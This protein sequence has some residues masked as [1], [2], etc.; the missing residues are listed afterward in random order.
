MRRFRIIRRN[1]TRITF[2]DLSEMGQKVISGFISSDYN[3]FRI[4]L[5]KVFPWSKEWG[6]VKA[7]QQMIISDKRG[8]LF[9]SKVGHPFRSKVG[10]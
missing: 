7:N 2:F 9:R 5:T 1:K 6:V 10:H 3:L 8:H 4:Q